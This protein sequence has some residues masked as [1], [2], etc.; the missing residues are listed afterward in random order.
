MKGGVKVGEIQHIQTLLSS[1]K[2]VELLVNWGPCTVCFG[3]EILTWIGSTS[4]ERRL[5]WGNS[6]KVLCTLPIPHSPSS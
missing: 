6:F 2:K 1:Y 5:G 3:L 4:K